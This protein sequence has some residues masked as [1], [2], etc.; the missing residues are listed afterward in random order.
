MAFKQFSWVPDGTYDHLNFFVRY[1]I[2]D[3]NAKT[4]I[5]KIWVDKGGPDHVSLELKQPWG[6]F[7]DFPPK[8]EKKG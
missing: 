6:S 5:S 8:P 3:G 1:V 2:V 4:V 7:P